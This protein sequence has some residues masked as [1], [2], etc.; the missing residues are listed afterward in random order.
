MFSITIQGETVEILKAKM[1]VFL[2]STSSAASYQTASIGAEAPLTGA[3]QAKLRGDATVVP[4]KAPTAAEKKAADKAAK[5]AADKAAKE[6]AAKAEAEALGETEEESVDGSGE[7][8]VTAED[9]KKLLLEVKAAYPKDATIIS[10][11]VQEQGKSKKLSE[12][13]E[14]NLGAV[15][16]KCRELLAKAGK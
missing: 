8:A 2:A 7:E 4:P 12:I 13:A 14:E 1:E 15:A 3:E 6:A 11:I 5:A 10:K 9:A 16:A